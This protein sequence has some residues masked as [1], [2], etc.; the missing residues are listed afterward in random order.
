MLV[1]TGFY[2]GLLG[3][4]F[5]VLSINVI[6]QR[7]SSK[8]G[9]GDGGVNRLA[10]AIRVHANFSEYLPVALVLMAIFELNNGSHLW[11]HILGATL[12]ISR[13]L[14]AVGLTRSIGVTKER[15]VGMLLTFIVIVILSVANIVTLFV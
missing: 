6:K 15:I 10:Q 2:A 14:H 8:V 1:V 5:I 11:L 7:R 13:I 9:I 4:L 3:L 12:F